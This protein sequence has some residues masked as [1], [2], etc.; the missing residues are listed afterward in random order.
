VFRNHALNCG[1]VTARQR[2]VQ[3]SSVAITR[4]SF[5]VA[6]RQSGCVHDGMTIAARQS[7]EGITA[8]GITAATAA[9]M[10]AFDALPVHLISR[11]MCVP[12]HGSTHPS[13]QCLMQAM[14]SAVVLPL[15]KVAINAFPMGTV[16][17]QLPP[18]TAACKQIKH[19]ISRAAQT[20]AARPSARFGRW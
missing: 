12:S 10:S 5:V 4:R 9:N 1:S 6:G 20:H 17:W 3:Q 2:C 13:P 8:D 7:L 11:W 18:R 19:G 14:P 16:S 15:A